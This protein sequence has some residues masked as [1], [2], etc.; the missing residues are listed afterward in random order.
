MKLLQHF[1]RCKKAK[2]VNFSDTSRPRCVRDFIIEVKTRY[3]LFYF[4][5]TLAS[6]T[7]STGLGDVTRNARCIQPA[8]PEPRLDDDHATGHKVLSKTHQCLRH[9]IESHEITNRT[10]QAQHCVVTMWKMKITH[11]RLE[12]SARM[13]L[14]R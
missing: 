12:E 14:C 1:S 13:L 9:T 4:D 2:L 7:N 5:S 6:N 10:E 8:R 11:V 3:A